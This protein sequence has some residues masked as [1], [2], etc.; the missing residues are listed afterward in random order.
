MS[1]LCQVKMNVNVIVIPRIRARYL[2][3]TILRSQFRRK[4]VLPFYLCEGKSDHKQGGRANVLGTGIFSDK[5]ERCVAL[6]QGCIFS[7]RFLGRV[8]GV[9]V[10]EEISVKVLNSIFFIQLKN[11]EC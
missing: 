8:C 3:V 6:A 5:E 4:V 10:T 7:L 9:G 2:M 1:S 11:S